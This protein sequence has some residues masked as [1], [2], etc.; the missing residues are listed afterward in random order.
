MRDG[1]AEA[2]GVDVEPQGL[3]VATE[4]WRDEPRVHFVLA[5]AHDLPFGGEQFDI[6]VSRLALQHMR[7]SLAFKELARVMRGGGYLYI[8]FHR[9]WY[10]LHYL[11]GMFTARPRVVTNRTRLILRTIFDKSRPEVFL[12]SMR[13]R[14]L[15][16]M[17]GLRSLGFW[18][19]NSVHM[20]GQGIFVK[21]H[22]RRH[23]RS[24]TELRAGLGG[25]VAILCSV[26]PGGG[27]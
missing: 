15:A 7:Q 8:L 19:P 2:W 14:K 22:D 25:L 18:F 27:T 11:L 26:L 6:V 3:S 12:T 24:S 16:R 1:A 9:I 4:L 10:Y 17:N 13:L 23:R 20:Y 5:D 21:D